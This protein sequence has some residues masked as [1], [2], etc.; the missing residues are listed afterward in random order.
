M[1]LNKRLNPSLYAKLNILI[2]FQLTYDT[3]LDAVVRLLSFIC[4]FIFCI[5]T[6]WSLLPV[7]IYYTS[8]YL[9]DSALMV[10]GEQLRCLPSIL[11]QVFAKVYEYEILIAAGAVSV[12]QI[13][14]AVAA[15][16]ND[17][18]NSN[19]FITVAQ[20]GSTVIALAVAGTVFTFLK[21]GLREFGFRDQLYQIWVSGHGFPTSNSR[22]R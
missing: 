18:N 8:W 6:S 11:I 12:F 1:I 17:K 14:Y 15:V 20:M 21:E 3:S 4:T 2:I 7:L 16:P 19:E 9:A 5:V 22:Q 13:G 10:S